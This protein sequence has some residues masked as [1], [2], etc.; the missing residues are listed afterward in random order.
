M[1]TVRVETWL[2]YILHE[3]RLLQIAAYLGGGDKQGDQPPTVLF[4]DHLVLL[5]T[6][7]LT[8]TKSILL[9]RH[10]V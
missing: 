7:C 6:G 8:R 2:M 1:S 3:N 5:N 10:R 9:Q 4:G